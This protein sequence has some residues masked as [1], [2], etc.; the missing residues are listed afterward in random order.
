MGKQFSSCN[1]ESRPVWGGE[2][3]KQIVLF[4]FKR[5]EKHNYTREKKTTLAGDPNNGLSFTYFSHVFFALTDHQIIVP[6]PGYLSFSQAQPHRT[7]L[8]EYF[9]TQS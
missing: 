7:E 4:I 1:Q 3:T 2:T 6:V 5:G 8:N 9:R